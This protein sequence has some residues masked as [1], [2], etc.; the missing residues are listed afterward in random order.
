MLTRDCINCRH[1]GKD[2]FT[3]EPCKTCT[4]TENVFVDRIEQPLKWEGDK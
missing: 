3:E 2:Y 4:E 1:D